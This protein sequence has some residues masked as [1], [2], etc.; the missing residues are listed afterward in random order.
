MSPYAQKAPGLSRA[1]LFVL[2]ACVLV[3]QGMVA[4]V[5]L[6]IPQLAASALHPSSSELLWAVDATSSSSPAC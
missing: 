6:L 1:A 5:N 2:C 3:A 4:A